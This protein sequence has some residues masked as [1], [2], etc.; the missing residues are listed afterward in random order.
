MGK[1]G[2]PQD[3]AK[4]AVSFKLSME[5]SIK[6]LMAQVKYAMLLAKGLGVE[7]NVQETTK[8]LKEAANQ[9]CGISI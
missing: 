5:N 2:T 9:P 4:A 1:E 6:H 7:R 8:L 3:Y